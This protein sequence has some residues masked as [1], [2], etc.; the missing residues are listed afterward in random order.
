MAFTLADAKNLSQDKLTNSVIDEFRKSPLLDALVFDDAASAGGG[1]SLSY[2]Y[3]RVTTLPTA[4]TRAI[5]SEYTAQEA[6]TTPVTVALKVFGGKFGIDRVLQK[7]EHK[8]VDLM[9]FQ[10]EQKIQATRALFA[11]MFI[12]GDSSSD[13]NAFDGLDKALTGSSTERVLATPI[14]LSSAAKIKENYQAFLWE[15]RQ[16]IKLLNGAP[17]ILGVNSDMFAVFQS[18]GD[19]STQFQL[20][21]NELGTEVVKY[22]NAVIMDMGDKP[23]TSNPIIELSLIHI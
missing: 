19:Y 21:R 15:L 23:G 11:D 18:I 22:G 6:K 20:T 16:T 2:T 10:L 12:N 14:D 13:G 9:T 3:N 7:Y 5:G 17:T 4:A 8:V 1:Q